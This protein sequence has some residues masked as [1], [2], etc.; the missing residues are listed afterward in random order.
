MTAI[1]DER[2]REVVAAIPAGC[3]ASYRD[4]ALACGA[5]VRHARTLNQRLQRGNVPGAHRVLLANGAIAPTALGD[6]VR[7]RQQL[8]AEGVP[9]INDRAHPS[10]RVDPAALRRRNCG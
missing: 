4:L 7:V 1:S 8:D 2:L 6:P 5:S 3:W 9:F 10:A